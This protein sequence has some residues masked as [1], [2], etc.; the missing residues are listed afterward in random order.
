ML[1]LEVNYDE[2]TIT[3]NVC[4]LSCQQHVL[5][6]SVELPKIFRA[7]DTYGLNFEH[8]DEELYSVRYRYNIITKLISRY[9]K[10]FL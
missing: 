4:D 9:A 10:K 7:I 8:F 6:H 3:F 1:E 5:I 2:D